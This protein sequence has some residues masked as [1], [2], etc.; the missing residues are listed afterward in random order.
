MHRCIWICVSTDVCIGHSRTLT[1]LHAQG[2]V[3]VKTNGYCQYPWQHY[4]PRTPT[5]PGLLLSS[6]IPINNRSHPNI[7]DGLS[8]QAICKWGRAVKYFQSQKLFEAP[9]NPSWGG[10]PNNLVSVLKMKMWK[11]IFTKIYTSPVRFGNKSSSFHSCGGLYL[12]CYIP[13]PKLEV[14]LNKEKTCDM[15]V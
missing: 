12:K 6:L 15:K 14:Q 3:A 2:K 13:L 10:H 8:L 5:S 9:P 11:G 4:E 1:E 7:F